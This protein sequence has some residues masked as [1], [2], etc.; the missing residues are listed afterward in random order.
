MKKAWLHQKAAEKN[1]FPSF[2]D[3]KTCSCQ[4]SDSALKGQCWW[5]EIT[6]ELPK[7]CPGHHNHI[8]VKVAPEEMME[9]LRG[10]I[11]RLQHSGTLLTTNKESKLSAITMVSPISK[12]F[13]LCLDSVLNSA[14]KTSR[15]QNLSDTEIHCIVSSKVSQTLNCTGI[16]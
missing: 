14:I 8:L 6:P 2:Y 10:S 15:E 7:H 13:C 16:F 5:T 9:V 3:C 4:R 1:I 12:Y 11:A